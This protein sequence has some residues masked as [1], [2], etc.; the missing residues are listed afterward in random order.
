MGEVFISREVRDRTSV[1]PDQDTLTL[2]NSST[3]YTFTVPEKCKKII[4]GMR[5]ADADFLYGWATGELNIT[6]RAGSY[7]IVEGVY[8]TGETLYF[9]CNDAAGKIIEIESWT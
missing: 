9:R 4:F 8:L 7:R 6:V 5:S 1:D 2:T 3:E